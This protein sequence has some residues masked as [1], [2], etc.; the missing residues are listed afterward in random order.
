[1]LRSS[2]PMPAVC[3][4][5]RGLSASRRDCLG[6]I[7]AFQGAAGHESAYGTLQSPHR[8]QRQRQDQPG[9]GLLAAT[10]PGCAGAGQ[11]SI[12]GASAASGRDTGSPSAERRAGD[13]F[14]LSATVRRHRGPPRRPFRT[15]L[16]P[17]AG[18]APTGRR[19]RS[20]LEQL[21]TKLSGIRAYLFDHYAMAGPVAPADSGELASNGRNIA[22]VIAAM[23]AQPTPAFAR[24]QAEFCRALPEFTGVVPRPAEAGGLELALRLKDG[25]ELVA[26]EKHLA[27]RTLHPGDAHAFVFSAAGPPC[28]A[29]RKPTGA[30]IRGCCGRCVTRFTA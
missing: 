21:R 5:R 4:R 10:D 1:M 14:P 27:G 25:G 30:C 28:F 3:F 12:R 26:A 16:G 8:A 29:S 18:A 15:P 2:G 11:R 13:H 23:Q 19:R 9:P 7:Q 24:L 20:A 17:P 6:P 22:A